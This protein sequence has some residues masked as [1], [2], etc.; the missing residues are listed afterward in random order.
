MRSRKASCLRCAERM[1]WSNLEPA[2]GG[3]FRGRFFFLTGNL[4][5]E[6]SCRGVREGRSGRSVRED[7]D[8]V[9]GLIEKHCESWT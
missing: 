5:T 4:L 7:R 1:G 3:D 8:D 2:A 6:R 9:P